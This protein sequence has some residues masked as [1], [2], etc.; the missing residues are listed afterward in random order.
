[1]TKKITFILLITC[2]LSVNA[3][4]SEEFRESCTSIMVGRKASAD[5][6]VMTSH[7]CDGRYR[8][9]MDIE[10]ASTY[11]QGSV[12]KIYQGALFTQTPDDMRRFMQ[13]TTLRFRTSDYEVALKVKGEIPQ[14]PETYAF[15]N[16]AYPCM[17]EKNLAI[18]ETTTEGRPELVNENGMFLIEELERIALQRCTTARDAI[19]LIG[20]LIKQYGYADI[21]EC[22]TLAD[23]N[24]V[25]HLEI[26]GEGKDR[27]GGVWAARRIPDD[28]V[29]ISANIPRIGELNL[30]D[31]DNYMASDNVF[32][33]AKRLGYW[34]GKEPFKF[35][36]VYG[37][38]EKPFSMREFF[39]LSSL[40]PSLN[41]SR[42]A[43]E[44][45][46]SVK[47]EKPI[48]VAD[49]LKFFRATYEGTTYDMTKNLLIKRKKAD[50]DEYETVRSPYAS[51][52]PTRDLTATYN[53]HKDS[54]INWVRNIAVPQC[55]Y[56]HVIQIRGYL[57]DE[58]ACVA[59]FA[60]DNPGQSPR[61][62]VYAKILRTPQS[63]LFSGH[64]YYEPEAF[65]WRMR[66][67]NKLASIR[68]QELRSKIETPRDS[69][70]NKMFA[71]QHRIENEALKI[72]REHGDVAGREY[73]TRYL[74]DCVKDTET[75]WQSI[76]ND[77]WFSFIRGL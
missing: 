38:V 56:A 60:N 37:G 73:L 4:R 31:K 53:Y 69:L 12:T 26:F 52:W 29:G 72:F 70:E 16:T 28:H 57:P 47:P 13:D 22:I 68:W 39:V 67:A 3:Q 74:E 33:A 14:A 8:T 6:S 76:E 41:L 45:P 23:K 19:V 7:T 32:E 75:I 61:I 30:K 71:E 24:E 65:A 5:G 66:R 43:D 20:K 25:W 48:S 1:M 40:A 50:S 51:P 35:W 2:V 62:P 49:V 18:G 17:N 64:K 27:I 59:Y 34:D 55:S 42:D 44:L 15:L 58:I 63:M 10:P 54:T 9:W 11:P 77:L 36:K 21:G 46:F